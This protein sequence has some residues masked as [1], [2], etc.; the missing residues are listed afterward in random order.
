MLDKNVSSLLQAIQHVDKTKITDTERKQLIA[1]SQ[2]LQAKVESPWETI[3]RLVWI[4]VSS[5]SPTTHSS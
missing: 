3:R 1:A 4:E 5:T 2:E